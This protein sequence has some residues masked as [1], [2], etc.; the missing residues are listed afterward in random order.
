MQGRGRAFKTIP[1]RNPLRPLAGR[2]TESYPHVMQSSAGGS[3]PPPRGDAGD[4]REEVI[5]P[6]GGVGLPALLHVPAGAR[7][8][9]VF[10]HGSGSGRLSPRNGFV[11]EALHAAGLGTLRVDLLVPGDA[12]EEEASSQRSL[13]I[14]VIAGR[15]LAA[16][17]WAAQRAGPD[18]MPTG[19]F[20]SS[21][22]AAAALVAAAQRGSPIRAVVC[23]GG[24]TDLA[25]HAAAKVA[26]PTLLLVGGLDPWVLRVNQE[27]LGL[28]AGERDLVVVPGA[29]HLFEEPGAMARVAAAAA[30]WFQRHLVFPTP[31]PGVVPA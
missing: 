22:G 20:G 29:G 31:V 30:A 1:W 17:R 27:T 6:C 12:L 13:D 3:A 5:I 7:G 19:A 2:R 10:A 9:V 26:V 14:A 28:L 24:R 8:L 11:A 18:P 4:L 16:A 21:T 23:R 15:L 25:G